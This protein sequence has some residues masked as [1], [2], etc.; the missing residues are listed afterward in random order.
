ME[1]VGDSGPPKRVVGAVRDAGGGTHGVGKLLDL[2]DPESIGLEAG[3]VLE[4]EVGLGAGAVLRE[5]EILGSPDGALGQLL[6]EDGD[7]AEA[8]VVVVG[9]HVDGHDLVL[10]GV[11]PVV[12]L[13]APHARV[14]GEALVVVLVSVERELRDLEGVVLVLA[15]KRELDAEDIP[16]AEIPR[17]RGI[18]EE[19]AAVEDLLLLGLGE[20]RSLLCCV[21]AR[22]GVP[23]GRDDGKRKGGEHRGTREGRGLSRVSA[24]EKK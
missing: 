19:D 2:V 1:H 17:M 12:V 18:I 23:A 14:V 21:E 8:R 4:V 11:A 16:L 7:G 22:G 13:H 9:V 24:P 6:L 3:R 20:S 10:V 15:A 5:V